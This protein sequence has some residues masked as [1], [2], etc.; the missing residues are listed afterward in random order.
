M[1]ASPPSLYA[2][3][4]HPYYVFA[5]DYVRTSAGIRVMH[6]I[7][8]TLNRLGE[9]AYLTMSASGFGQ[10]RFEDGDDCMVEGVYT[11]LRL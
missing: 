6:Q 1:P 10:L 8:D 2:R 5:P 9:E 11:K 4:R 3:R 7:C